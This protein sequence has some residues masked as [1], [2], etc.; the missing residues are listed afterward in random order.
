M[1]DDLATNVSTFDAEMWFLMILGL[2]WCMFMIFAP[3][4]MRGIQDAIE[5]FFGRERIEGHPLQSLAFY[6]IVGV[7]VLAI[8][9]YLAFGTPKPESTQPKP[10]MGFPHNTDKS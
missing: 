3:H 5:G 4:V 7:A 1:I 10:S 9:L 6:R 8:L 2:G